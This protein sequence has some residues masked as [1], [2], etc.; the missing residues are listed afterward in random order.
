[1]TG[2]GLMP[3]G[4]LGAAIRQLRR[5][6]DAGTASGLS[7]SDLLKRFAD[8]RDE[9][10]F[11]A[12]VARHGPMVLA[13]CRG[14]TRS[15]VDAEDAFQATFLILARKA[16]SIW[17]GESLGGWLHRV[18]RR[19]AIQAVADAGRRRDRERAGGRRSSAER[20]PSCPWDD[21]LPVL[22]EEI[23]RLPEKY[24][25]AIVLCDLE[26]LTR[27]EA[28]AQLGW[29]P[30][31]VAG[32]LSR[33]RKLLHDRMTRRGATPSFQWIAATS[34]ARA[35]VVPPAWIEAA[36]GFAVGRNGAGAASSAAVSWSG[37][38]LKAM[39]LTKL[40][41]SILAL[42]LAVGAASALLGV[43]RIGRGEGR[44]AVPIPPAVRAVPDQDSPIS[45]EARPAPNG[46]R[47]SDS[48]EVV[49][50]GTVLDPEGKPFAGAKV[51]WLGQV[52]LPV[53][54]Q[55]PR[56]I[57]GADGR[58][59]FTMNRP[60]D[61]P[62]P[63]MSKSKGAL[64]GPMHDLSG[65]V[66]KVE[67]YGVGF[68]TRRSIG[69]DAKLTLVRDDAPV[70]GRIID[71]Q[72]RPVAGARVRGL[73]LMTS[74]GSDGAE[75]N[76]IA[77]LDALKAAKTSN[78]KSRAHNLLIPRF[79]GREDAVANVLPPAITG[80]DGRFRL[81]G[82]G[83]ER[84]LMAMIEGPTIESQIVLIATRAMD[85]LRIEALP[86]G[87]RGMYSNRD[88]D[89]IIYGTNFDHVAGPTRPVDGVV[90]DIDTGQPLAGVAIVAGR[91]SLFEHESH[92]RS[93]SDASG[94]F[95]IEGLPEGGTF[96]LLAYPPRN[97]PYPGE[98]RPV[99]VGRGPGVA[100][101]EFPLRRGVWVTGRIIDRSSGVP[102][103]QRDGSASH[104]LNVDPA[105]GMT[106]GLATGRVEYHA[107][108]D[109]PNLPKRPVQMID[110]V[111]F[112]DA[113]GNYRLAAY[114]GRGLVAA[115]VDLEKYVRG[116]GMEGIA[117]KT[118]LGNYPTYP[119]YFHPLNCN[120]VVEVNPPQG[121]ESIT[122][123]LPLVT[124]GTRT[125][126]VLD[127]QGQPLSGALV[128]GLS[129][130]GRTTLAG[131]DFTIQ[132]IIA[133]RP[134]R[135]IF[136]HDE[137]KLIGLVDLKDAEAGGSPLKVNLV[138]WASLSGRLV[139]EE[140][141]PRRGALLVH[142]PET[143]DTFAKGGVPSDPSKFRL[144]AEGRFRIVG[145][146]PG[147]PYNISPSY[148][149]SPDLKGIVARGLIFESGEDRD[150]GDVMLKPRE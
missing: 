111:S 36:V 116:F 125:G 137:R 52:G 107:F 108:A 97:L 95:R 118:E 93:V 134:R 79:R 150:L 14:V 20:S 5:V 66:A 114:P 105:T 1:M 106:K 13:T 144:S 124:G 74:Q 23:G 54:T 41:K 60:K 27:D 120:C 131:P 143:T 140:G 34:S 43:G 90:R 142:F 123:D 82:V 15:H 77:W 62:P 65:L 67:G 122:A 63:R 3:R 40:L 96:P 38:V 24:R 51:F 113:D 75:T 45:L 84:V 78:E 7:D 110:Q 10:A 11:A 132:G 72:G 49:Y 64:R 149:E 133:G 98:R 30:G 127:P 136:R 138:P 9:S 73:E 89:G 145:L 81:I 101:I 92:L 126:V 42:S 83:R 102:V 17:V 117:G 28:A 104:F 47:A 59:R 70:S 25:M 58:F 87:M 139:D 94:H 4:Q 57:S 99:E 69:R 2:A 121:V 119:S 6:F 35:T 103:G 55:E 26:D 44:E 56:T 88:G 130:L 39:F 80:E 8:S 112:A 46:T 68:W 22:H 128:A 148:D 146:V 33:G 147:K 61:I 53:S 135:L 29:P 31:T 86:R 32:R 129:D 48:E 76:V 21:L 37:R 16:G 19:V 18:A 109:N 85:T 100:S 141:Q 115:M 12:M 71:L 91:K 50:E